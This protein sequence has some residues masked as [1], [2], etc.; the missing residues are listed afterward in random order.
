MA[1]LMLSPTFFVGTGFMAKKFLTVC[2]G[3]FLCLINYLG[4]H[5]DTEATLWNACAILSFNVVVHVD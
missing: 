4:M 1:L 5:L 2:K 3:L